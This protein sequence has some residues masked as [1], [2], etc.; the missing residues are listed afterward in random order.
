MS[1]I[2]VPDRPF[3]YPMR[4]GPS[5]VVEQCDTCHYSWADE[6][7]ELNCRRNPPTAFLVVKPRQEPGVISA[8]P[9]VLAEHWC[10]EWR[11]KNTPTTG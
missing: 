4:T 10:G 3:A 9:V 11:L 7:K 8:H 5:S 2:L 6:H 1:G